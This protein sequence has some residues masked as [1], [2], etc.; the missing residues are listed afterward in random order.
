[1]DYEGKALPT[2]KRFTGHQ[3]E[4]ENL[5]GGLTFMQARFYLAGVGRF[6]SADSIVPGAGNPQAL[7]RYSYSYNSPL[8]FIDP[9]GHI[10]CKTDDSNCWASIGHFWNGSEYEYRPGQATFA[11]LNLLNALLSEVGFNTVSIL[12]S[13][14]K[15]LG[16][17]LADI[18]HYVGGTEK[19]RKLVGNGKQ[20]DFGYTVGDRI[21]SY[22]NGAPVEGRVR[23]DQRGFDVAIRL[24]ADGSYL[25]KH[26]SMKLI[27]HEFGHILNYV[28]GKWFDANLPATKKGEIV[29]R[30]NDTNPYGLLERDERFAREFAAW[31]YGSPNSSSEY[32]FDK[33]KWFEINLGDRNTRSWRDR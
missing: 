26:A 13:G 10:S 27:A 20:I 17:V 24:N 23:K 25:D 16:A 5:T 9:S 11:S 2:D 19:L 1:M 8:R 33:A 22:A 6:V 31:I 30:L 4:P 32:D 29:P 12:D 14:T 18:T 28:S 7:N 15:L 3:S 21:D